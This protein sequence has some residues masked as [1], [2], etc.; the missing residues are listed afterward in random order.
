MTDRESTASEK[1][2]NALNEIALYIRMC[3]KWT[4]E[5]REQAGLS[6]DGS[7]D[8][9][10][11]VTP[12]YQQFALW[13]STIEDA[14]TL[15]HSK[16]STDDFEPYE[17]TLSIDELRREV[18]WLWDSKRL[19]MNAIRDKSE[20]PAPRVLK[21]LSRAAKWPE[22]NDLGKTLQ[23]HYRLDIIPPVSECE[24]GAGVWWRI[25][26]GLTVNDSNIM[27]CL[28]MLAICEELGGKQPGET[29]PQY[30]RRLI[31]FIAVQ[32]NVIGLIEMLI[33]AGYDD[34]KAGIAAFE[35]FN[36]VEFLEEYRKLG[37]H[38]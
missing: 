7:T 20:M 27:N 3:L 4:R 6:I 1:I 36:M 26:T 34:K 29:Y 13:A 2:S 21:D 12:G 11:P 37:H 19:L 32:P 22:D 31:D 30:L 5:E 17:N 8:I 33:A 24:G 38:P 18:R 23:R 25:R 9:N 16:K 10:F 14:S 35:N 28:S 15:I